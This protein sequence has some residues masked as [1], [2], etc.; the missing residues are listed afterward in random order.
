VKPSERAARQPVSSSG[1]AAISVKPLTTTTRLRVRYAP[2]STT[3]IPMA[4]L[5]PF[6]NTAASSASSSR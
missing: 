3:A 4:S 6:R 5:K 2:T 1:C